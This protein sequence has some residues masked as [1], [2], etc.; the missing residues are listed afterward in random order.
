MLVPTNRRVCGKC[1]VERE[2]RVPIEDDARIQQI[3]KEA[4]TI[5]VVGASPKPWRD[6]G[7]IAQFLVNKGYTVFPVNPKYDEVIGLKCYPNLKA[8]PHKID[9]VDIFR[10][11]DEVLPT[12]E[13]AIEIGAG[14]VWMQ[15]EVINYEA[16]ELAEKADLQVVMDRCIA[17][18][19]RHLLD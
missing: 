12:V 3:L 1:G 13:E 15:L 2:T 19:H 17:V 14:T 18:E 9:V 7:S 4:K 5:A 16:A 10:R 11:S 8:I 6:S